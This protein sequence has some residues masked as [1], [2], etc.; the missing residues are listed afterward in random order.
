MRRS[1]ALCAVQLRSLTRSADEYVISCRS[2]FPPP[3]ETD[4]LIVSGRWSAL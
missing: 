1:L 4:S 3:I 2:L